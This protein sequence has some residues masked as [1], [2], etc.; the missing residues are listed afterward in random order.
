M[1]VPI[2]TFFT[3]RGCH[4]CDS[5]LFAL[6]RELAGVEHR[7]EQ[8][9]IDQQRRY[10]ARYDHHVPVIWLNGVE[11]CRHRLDAPLLRAALASA[12]TAWSG[13]CTR[14]P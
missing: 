7:L 10:H 11:V 9:D 8:I 1:D 5:A 12:R 13:A 2:V 4:L 14:S 6:S 3:R